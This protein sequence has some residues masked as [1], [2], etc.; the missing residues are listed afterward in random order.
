MIQPRG[1]VSFLTLLNEESQILPRSLT[2][3][4]SLWSDILVGATAYV[5]LVYI[6]YIAKL[7]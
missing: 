4:P 1:M 5:V 3:V 2:V 7:F 6:R